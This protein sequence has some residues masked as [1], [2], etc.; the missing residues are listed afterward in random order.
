MA[1]VE[2]TDHQSLAVVGHLD[3]RHDDAPADPYD[4]LRGN[5]PA[6]SSPKGDLG[7]AFMTMGARTDIKGILDSAQ[8]DIAATSDPAEKERIIT[9]ARQS[10]ADRRLVLDEEM[11][12]G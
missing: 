8:R 4:L 6:Q 5:W 9:R 1:R 12:R 11:K 10:V 7:E 3:R 2:Q